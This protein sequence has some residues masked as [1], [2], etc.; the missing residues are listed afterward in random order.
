M[1]EEYPQA[2]NDI[3]NGN[4]KCNRGYCFIYGYE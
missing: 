1:A 4:N 2:F 3:K